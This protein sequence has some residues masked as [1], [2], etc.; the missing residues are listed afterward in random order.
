[1]ANLTFEQGILGSPT[2]LLVNETRFERNMGAIQISNKV[3]LG[4]AIFS[5]VFVDNIWALEIY[6]NPNTIQSLQLEISDCYFNDVVIIGDDVYGESCDAATFIENNSFK[7]G[8]I[9]CFLI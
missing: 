6:L 7:L 1:M 5:S 3:Y 8:L 9:S 4:V 2:G